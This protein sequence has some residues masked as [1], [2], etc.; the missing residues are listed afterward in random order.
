MILSPQNSSAQSYIGIVSLCV[1]KRKISQNLTN[2]YSFLK[3][4]SIWYTWYENQNTW[5]IKFKYDISVQDK[6]SFLAS[7]LAKL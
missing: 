3:L 2:V 5:F 1:L 4:R 7:H 6:M